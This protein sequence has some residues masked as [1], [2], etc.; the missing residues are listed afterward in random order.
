MSVTSFNDAVVAAVA[1]GWDAAAEV[2]VDAV[3]GKGG[4]K[5]EAFGRRRNRRG[6][7]GGR[8]EGGFFGPVLRVRGR[9]EV[10]DGVASRV[11]G[12]EEG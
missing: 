9:R 2:D 3:E 4:G 8:R 10:H 12:K 5:G 7:G 11:R 6:G 1:K